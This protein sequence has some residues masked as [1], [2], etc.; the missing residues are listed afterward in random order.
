M[1]QDPQ[2]YH[3]QVADFAEDWQPF[4]GLLEPAEQAH[5]DA[6]V[7]AALERPYPGHVQNEAD[8]K[9]PIV[10]SMLVEQ[11]QQIVRLRAEVKKNSRMTT[12]RPDQASG[13]RNYEPVTE[14]NQ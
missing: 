7:D 5:W 8:A 11:Q 4:R 2:L 3:E 9:W 13:A 14:S 1:A 6:L 10:F 12:E